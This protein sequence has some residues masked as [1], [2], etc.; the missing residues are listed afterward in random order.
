MENLTH[1]LQRKVSLKN[2]KIWEYVVVGEMSGRRNVLLRKCPVGELSGQGYVRWGVVRRVNVSR[3]SVLK[4]ESVG[5][6]SG[7]ET[8]LQSCSGMKENL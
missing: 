8:V 7:R 4:E 5:E 3:G 1:Q 6:L 2:A